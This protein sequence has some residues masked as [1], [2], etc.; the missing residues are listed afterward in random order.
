MIEIPVTTMPVF[1]IPFHVSYILY[2]SRFSPLLARVYFRFALEM[3]KLTNTP[4]SLLL[5]PLDFLG[6]DDIKELSFF[7]AMDL[8]SERKIKLVGELIDT[9]TSQFEVVPLRK[10]AYALA[11]ENKMSTLI[12]RLKSFGENTP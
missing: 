11:N 9:Y 2:E 3:C 7:P 1:K 4:P 6:C 12:P 10:Q 5:H 8:P